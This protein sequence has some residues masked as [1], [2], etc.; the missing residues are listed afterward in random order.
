MR[1]ILI[2]VRCP[3]GDKSQLLIETGGPALGGQFNFPHALLS[4]MLHHRVHHRFSLTLSAVRKADGHPA[5]NPASA[6]VFLGKRPAG[7]DRLRTV[8]DHAMQAGF[9]SFVKFIMKSLFLDKHRLTDRGGLFETRLF[10][11][12]K[13]QFHE[14]SSLAGLIL[15]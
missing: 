4:E 6:S 10:S 5:D 14:S 8:A 15:A 13:M 12:E 7:G 9:V 3:R 11:S 1:A 2:H